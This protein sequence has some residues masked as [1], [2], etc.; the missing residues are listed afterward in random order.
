MRKQGKP[1]IE[2]KVKDRRNN[3]KIEMELTKDGGEC[4]YTKVNKKDIDKMRKL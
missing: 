4:N 2:S 3:K 1:Q